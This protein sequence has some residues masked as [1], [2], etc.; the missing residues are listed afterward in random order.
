MG[1]GSASKR[2]ICRQPEHLVVMFNANP[3]RLHLAGAENNLH[4]AKV[5]IE[6]DVNGALTCGAKVEKVLVWKWNQWAPTTYGTPL[7]RAPAIRPAGEAIAGPSRSLMLMR[8]ARPHTVRILWVSGL[9]NDLLWNTVPF[10][11]AEGV[12]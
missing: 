10:S 7:T 1:F 5:L 12:F 6:A 9:A 3:R 2:H 11:V 4:A 8:K